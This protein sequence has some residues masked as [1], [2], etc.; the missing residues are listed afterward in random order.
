M[1][2]KVHFL[3]FTRKLAITSVLFLAPLHFLKIGF[4]G[5]Q[6]GTLVSVWAVAPLLMSFPIGRINDRISMAGV[7]RIGMLAQALCLVGLAF[8]ESFVLTAVL[9]L[10]SGAA[11][12]A[13][14]VSL[15][16]LFYKDET[17]MDQNRKYGLYAFWMNFGP[18]VGVLSGAIFVERGGYR[19]MLL[20]FAAVS[21]LD[22]VAV[23]GF[24]GE[25]FHAVTM[26]DYGRD[27]LRPRTLGFALFIF[28][29][30]VHWAVEGTV[31]SPFLERNLGL[32][33]I[34]TPL[35]I[36]AGLVVMSFVSFFFRRAEFRPERNKRLMFLAMGVS[37]AGLMLMTIKPPLLSFGF[38]VVHEAG[39]GALGVL[40]AV[41]VSRLFAKESIGGSAGLMLSVQVLGQMV[42][43]MLLT[44]LGFSTSL[45]IPFLVGGGLLILN[46]VYGAL[47]FRRVPY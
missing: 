31:Y 29:L 40:I 13:L 46:A 8:T 21:L 30:A 17:E 6:I 23:R 2:A 18:A 19:A 28:L 22:F 38:R 15:Q 3:N 12:N 34:L 41:F 9:F 24:G 35:Y 32:T 1:H 26:R 27:L 45:A 25:I 37:G 42:G 33:G 14:D 47:V 44:P 4:S 36:G 7:V 10:L 5:W 39:D 11:N 43:G 20:V 16:S